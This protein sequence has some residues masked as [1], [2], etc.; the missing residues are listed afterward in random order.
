MK[1][2]GI[3]LDAVCWA[4]AGLRDVS[5]DVA[6]GEV[7]GLLGPNGSGKSSLLRC[8]YRRVRPDSGAVLL[9]GTDVWRVP[10][11][12]AA[13]HVAAVTQDAP[14]DPDTTAEQTVALG[15]LPYLGALGRM[16][17]DDRRVVHDA[18]ERCDVGAL[19]RRR[20]ATLSGGERQRVNL[21]RAL[22]QRPRLLVLDE[23]TNHLDLHHQVAL[24]GLLA[25]LD[26]TVL[27]ALHDLRLAAAACD[28]V[29]VLRDGVLAAEGPPGTVLTP[30]L[31]ADVYRVTADVATT[32]SG[33]LSIDLP[34]PRRPMP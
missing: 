8:V 32:P 27:I 20:M 29:A 3:R 12:E 25:V 31:L 24:F 2:A 13:R 33:A 15:R 34:I 1:P 30:A 7:V 22:A 21:A 11:R 26:T 6:P 19:A 14:A 28:R 17:R 23:P 9:D 5:F 18:M 16:S 4:P 10:A